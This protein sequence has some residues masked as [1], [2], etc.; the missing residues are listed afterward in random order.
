MILVLVVKEVLRWLTHKLKL[1]KDWPLVSLILLHLLLYQAIVQLL[2]ITMY[3][4]IAFFKVS[5]ATINLKPT[6][7]W[8][9]GGSKALPACLPQGKGRTTL[10]WLALPMF[11]W[12]NLLFT[13][14]SLKSVLPKK[15][16]SYS[17][18]KWQICHRNFLNIT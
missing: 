13:K 18:C 14:T 15:E 9:W 7:I 11:S 2:K 10:Y 3:S 16:F 17:L 1:L 12:I 6:C 8:V 4:C 5:F